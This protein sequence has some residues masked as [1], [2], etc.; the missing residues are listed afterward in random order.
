MSWTAAAAG[1][2][3]PAMLHEFRCWFDGCTHAEI[4]SII[5]LEKE[6]LDFYDITSRSLVD[7]SDA[8]WPLKWVL[9]RYSSK[10]IFCSQKSI[11]ANA[12][13]EYLKKFENKMRWRSCF[14]SAS[15]GLQDD[16]A[17]R[18]ARRP[19]YKPVKHCN[20]SGSPELQAFLGRFRALVLEAA[21]AAGRK[22]ACG[23]VCNMPF[24][25]KY[26]FKLLRELDLV[27]VK[28]DKEPGFTLQPLTSYVQSMELFLNQPC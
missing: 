9:C 27:A 26:G 20:V 5:T 8:P 24:A 25:V 7:I 3:S 1:R 11:G 4:A 21:V 16:F 6:P 15:S 19:K 14:A 12:L 17:L 28:N 22:A 13:L 2:P 23:R 18:A 10:H